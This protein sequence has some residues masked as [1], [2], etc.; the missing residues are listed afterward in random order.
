MW[1]ISTYIYHK[2]LNEEIL[3]TQQYTST[4]FISCEND[5]IILWHVASGKLHWTLRGQEK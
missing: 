4:P 5:D 1:I 2:N 3:K